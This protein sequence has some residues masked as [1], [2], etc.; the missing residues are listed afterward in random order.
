MQF[1]NYPISS[2]QSVKVFTIRILFS[3]ANI[4]ALFVW[5][6]IKNETGAYI[7]PNLFNPKWEINPNSTFVFIH[8]SQYTTLPSRDFH[9]NRNTS[10]RSLSLSLSLS[11]SFSLSISFPFSIQILKILHNAKKK[12]LENSF[13]KIVCEKFAQKLFRKLFSSFLIYA[14]K[15]TTSC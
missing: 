14:H 12:E 3:Q 6:F 13:M 7:L 11:L 5:N 8:I 9:P 4:K 1:R 2:K 10:S 15:R